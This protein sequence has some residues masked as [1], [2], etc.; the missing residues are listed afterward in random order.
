LCHTLSTAPKSLRSKDLFKIHP[1]INLHFTQLL[2][3]TIH[4]W[5]RIM[6]QCVAICTYHNKNIKYI[7]AGFFLLRFGQCWF[8]LI[9]LQFI[10]PNPNPESESEDPK[11]QRQRGRILSSKRHM[12]Q[13]TTT[14]THNSTQNPH[15]PPSVTSC[16]WSVSHYGLI[17]EELFG[18][19]FGVLYSTKYY[20]KDASH[21]DSFNLIYFETEIKCLSS[22]YWRVLTVFSTKLCIY[23]IE[24]GSYKF[25]TYF[26]SRWLFLQ[27]SRLVFPTEAG[28]LAFELAKRQASD[29]ANFNAINVWRSAGGYHPPPPTAK[30]IRMCVCVC[31]CVGEL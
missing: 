7:V 9:A 25:L 29:W 16:S 1:T 14:T 12:T 2:H 30:Y 26:H 21:Y 3:A 8:D 4:R 10:Y 18:F 13:T 5:L 22:N 27:C 15:S 11:A 19:G 31:V 17:L 24:Y 23:L 20:E 6:C 28:A